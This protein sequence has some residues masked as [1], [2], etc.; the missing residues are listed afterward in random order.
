M[1][2]DNVTKRYSRE[3]KYCGRLMPGLDSGG[4]QGKALEYEGKQWM[5]CCLDHKEK[6]DLG[7]QTIAELEKGRW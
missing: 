6:W 3:C 7:R 5:F 1:S 4:I 2:F